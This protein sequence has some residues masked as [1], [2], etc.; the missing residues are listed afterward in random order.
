[1]STPVAWKSY[2]TVNEPSLDSEHQQIIEL[3]RRLYVAIRA[4]RERVE[5]RN[6]LERLRQYTREHFD[7][8][9]HLMREVGFPKLDAHKAEHD[10]MRRKT[11]A[12]HEDMNYVG[13]QEM[14]QFLKTWWT[15]HIQSMDKEYAPYFAVAA[16]SMCPT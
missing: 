16:D 4:N 7:H 3:I 12:L 1:M 10:E 11:L 14:L 5:I 8:E 15:N 13:G 6:I 2:Y 9:E